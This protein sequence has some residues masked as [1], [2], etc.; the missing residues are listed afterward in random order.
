[1]YSEEIEASGFI[2]I[3]GMLDPVTIARVVDQL[4]C[5]PRTNATK[6][7]GGNYFGIRNLLSVAPYVCELANSAC[8]R[9]I[10][11]PIVG[12]E[13]QAVRG[14]FFDKTPEANWKVPWHQDLT[15]SVQQK[16]EAA[17]FRCWTRKAGI[18]H[19][20]PPTLVME[21]ILTLRLHLDDTDEE[22]GALKVIPG[23][24][25]YGRLT[26]PAIQRTKRE[27]PPFVCAAKKGDV[28]AMR[29]LL[30]HSS[31]VSS[32]AFHRRVIHLEYAAMDL[33]GGL[34]WSQS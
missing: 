29:P 30:L 1:M 32:N 19:V 14:I 28:L 10:V 3:S 15:I 33:P 31:S 23:S 9:S 22:S 21:E 7:R 16:R 11:D 17:G 24:H 6:Q 13:A 26:P 8:V 12:K 34:E 2:V 25:K 18:T 5:I 20:Q 4:R 27:T